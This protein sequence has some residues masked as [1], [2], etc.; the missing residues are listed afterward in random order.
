MYRI[1]PDVRI[2]RRLRAHI[3]ADDEGHELFSSPNILDV[4][5]WLLD[6]E[7][8]QLNFVSDDEQYSFDLRP[9]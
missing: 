5:R 7:Y 2:S 8:Y 6:R 9:I 1:Y 3:V 4:I